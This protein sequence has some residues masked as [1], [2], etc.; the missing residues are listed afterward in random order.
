MNDESRGYTEYGIYSLLINYNDSGGRTA[1]TV[2][3]VD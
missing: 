1:F 3:R 2:R